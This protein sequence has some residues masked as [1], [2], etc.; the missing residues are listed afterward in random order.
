LALAAVILNWN[1]TAQTLKLLSAAQTWEEAAPRLIVVDNASMAAELELLQS[2]IGSAT[3]LKSHT[4]LGF[5]GGC[6]LGL[7]AA[8]RAG[9]SEV[10]LLNNDAMI[11]K[12]SLLTLRRTLR[13]NP[14][15]AVV[16]PV[17]YDQN[18]P[19]EILSAGGRDIAAGFNT[20]LKHN[21][22]LSEAAE[23]Y[24]VD[25]VPGTTA[26]IRARALRE[27]GLFD[28]DYFFSGE[29][30]D[31]CRRFNQAGY[32]NCI[33]AGASAFHDMH[34]AGGL[35]NDLYTYYS[36]RNRLVYIFKA[37]N[38]PVLKRILSITRWSATGAILCLKAL[39]SGNKNQSKAF[40]LAVLHGLTKRWGGRNYLFMP[41][42]R[43]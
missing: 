20:H 16:G 19:G 2:G 42:N 8:L 14:R 10:L 35:R 5:A 12:S 11:D 6:N 34:T 43:I 15:I 3:L 18:N 29:M 26:L 7:R 25:Y 36:L 1:N 4:N 30:A 22:D 24:E 32:V 21:P 31:L 39:L 40:G 13:K 37:K 28:E 38:K 17:V 23:Q 33:D 9:A 27:T 41:G